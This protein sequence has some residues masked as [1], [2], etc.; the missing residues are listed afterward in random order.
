MGE[1]ILTGQSGVLETMRSMITESDRLHAVVENNIINSRI[2]ID[3]MEIALIKAKKANEEL[4]QEMRKF[5]ILTPNEAP[6]AQT[7]RVYY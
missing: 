5:G 3:E 6:N 7:D 4:K 2:L 1:E